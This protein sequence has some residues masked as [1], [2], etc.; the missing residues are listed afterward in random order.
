MSDNALSRLCTADAAQQRIAAL[1]A[2]L[3][4]QERQLDSLAHANVRL[5][6]VHGAIQRLDGLLTQG[7]AAGDGEIY[8]RVLDD[9]MGLT[10]AHY[11]A[12]AV[13]GEDGRIRQFVARGFDPAQ[14]QHIGRWPQGHGLL[15]A[16]YRDGRVVRVAD[17]ARDPRAAGFP[18]GHPLLHSLIGVPLRRGERNYGVLY[19]A[20]KHGHEP[21]NDH[22]EAILTLFAREIAPA[23][24]RQALLAELREKNK[25]LKQE[26]AEQQALIQRLEAAQSQLLQSEKMAAIGQL[27]AGVAHEINNP[28]GYIGSNLNPLGR[29]VETLLGLIDRY[30]AVE[31]KLDAETVAALARERQAIDLDYIRQDIRDLLRESGEGIARIKQI[32]QDLK[33]FSRVD[34]AERQ[35]ADLHRGLDS[36]LNV[37][38]NE[39][40]YK[41]EV[42]KDY[43][44]LPPVE[45]V[46]SQLNQVFLNLLVNA[47]H[48]IDTRGTITLRTGVRN[49]EVFVEIA[50]TGRGI[51][52]EHR[53]RIFEPFFTT[54][55]VGQGTGLGLSLAYGIV[56]K[57]GGR[58]EVES[59]VGKGA[60]F[61]VWLPVRRIGESGVG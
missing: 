37:V 49:D 51:A 59:E 52:P 35:W 34:E 29:Y 38:W 25:R 39:L 27:A 47:A 58:I 43:G 26:H 42:V 61:R 54:K 21:F 20:D 5:M 3:A 31:A 44:T 19:L 6:L 22:D 12:V 9:L 55:P 28:V 23:L 2:E 17:I 45:C 36:T 50:D 14:A 1:E 53:N 57:H 7:G 18:D 10:H 30:Q 40:K 16:L 46:P 24:E 56:Q 33:D 13:F 48:A 32:V 60:A 8:G 11:G 15:Q 41:A 4:S